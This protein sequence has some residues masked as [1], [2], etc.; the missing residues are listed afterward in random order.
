MGSVKV[1]GIIGALAAIACGALAASVF[2]VS[3][4]NAAA[5]EAPGAYGQSYRNQLAYS[6]REGWNNDPNGLLYADG[7][8][9]MYYQYN[10]DKNANDGAG[11]TENVWGH[12]SWGH[13]TST[14]LVHWEEQPVAIPAYQTVDGEF[15]GAMFSGSAVYD[16]SNT[17]G[18][19][20]TD[21]DGKVL[22]GQGIVA[23]LT[24]PN[25]KKG[26]QRQI[27]AYSKD[28]GNSFVLYGEILSA[29]E[30]GGKGDGEFRDPKVS[31]NNKLNKWLMTVGGGSIRTYTS[32]NLLD[33]EYV[34]E[35]GFW[36][37]CPDMFAFN[38]GGEEKYVL[39][40]SPE[41]KEQSHK[42]NGTTR[43]S[44]YYP[45]EYYTVGELTDEG[46]FVA[47][48]PLKRLSYGIDC[49]AL[50][51]F[52]NVPDGKVY[53][54]SWSASWKSVDKYATLRESYNG[55]MTVAC[56]FNLVKDGEGYSLLRTPVK[57]Y[58]NLRS[59]LLKTYDGRLE[60]GKNALAG[61]RADIVDISAE[62]D[63]SGSDATCA[64]MKLRASA[65]EY[66]S[67]RYDV[68][69]STLTLDRSAS[70]LLA[71]STMLYDLPCKARVNL[72]DGKL[73]LRIIVD[74]AFISVFANGGE[75][76]V[77]SAVFPS[78]LSNS[79]S[80]LSDGD[81]GLKAEIYSMERIFGTAL[82]SNKLIMQ[83]D[84]LQTNIGVTTPV[85]ASSFSENYPYDIVYRI[86]DGGEN[87]SLRVADGIAYVT[88]LKAGY[89]KIAAECG[90]Q[91]LER[92]IWINNDGFESNVG[93]E[94]SSGGFSLKKDAGYLL[95]NDKDKNKDVFRF[96][97]ERATDFIY[98]A[99]LTCENSDDDAGGLVFGASENLYDYYV[100]TVGFKPNLLKL[101]RAGEGDL[102]V[103]PHSFD[104]GR[105]VKVTLI[106]NGGVA[107]A[108]VN[109]EK[110][111][112]LVCP[113]DGYHGGRLGLN[114][115]NASIIFNDLKLTR[116]TTDFCGFNL[117]GQ[118]VESVVNI[119]DGYK[120]Q[121]GD[122]TVSDGELNLNEG[123]VKTLAGNTEYIFRL[124]TEATEYDLKFTTHF[125]GVE[126]SADKKDYIFSE[127]VTLS[128][129]GQT[130]INKVLLDGRECEFT[131][132]GVKLIIPQSVVSQLTAGDHTVEAFTAYGR[133]QAVINISD[134]GTQ[135]APVE[136][137]AE[138][139]TKIFLYIDL[140]IFG[141]AILAY[142]GFT[143]YKK[144]KKR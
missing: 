70:S 17:S 114:V 3:G 30:D 49:Y 129:S 28:G 53:G 136:E 133:P 102:K 11:A 87:V 91:I 101:W 31:W 50:Q 142:I 55:G 121:A 74:R 111:P 22:K 51:T 34:G 27:A 95:A 69:S 7:V 137:E 132:N 110:A 109:D 138:K 41:D 40:M 4:G 54:I 122:F 10:W 105:T 107:K 46:K 128:L 77:F 131:L 117:A 123:Y 120:L 134:D 92:K 35:T 43:E 86:T 88:A 104:A 141:A 52:N 81:I 143:A 89:A 61:V 97:E 96:T 8:Y 72:K 135:A 99:T 18:L 21:D 73:N 45:S 100:L 71:K 38:V 126:M 82:Y 39:A 26:G 13:A 20:D 14:D 76:S 6:A 48:Q 42:Y 23:V 15:Y 130:E 57:A 65:A 5:E 58:E 33:W 67:L 80:L 119:R 75:A 66:V 83:T 12:M 24:Q 84:D 118:T 60:A 124:T 59:E 125:T 144:I 37:E 29:K 127:D 139:A 108:F 19:F 103:V 44:A 63:F 90:G 79:Y 32:D 25:D 16:E 64:K 94:Y 36:G 140:A 62:L 112:A 113:L 56:E 115:F 85:I 78:A 1:K 106:V 98:T 93:F 68:E 47:E 2:T 9:H 116:Q